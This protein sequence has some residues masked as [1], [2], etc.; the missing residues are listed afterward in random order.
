MG[1]SLHGGHV[2]GTWRA[3]F[4]TQVKEGSGGGASIFLWGL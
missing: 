1:I 3:D 4:E 2:G